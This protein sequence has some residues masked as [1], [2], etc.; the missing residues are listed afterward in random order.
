MLEFNIRTSV[1]SQED[2]SLAALSHSFPHIVTLVDTI[3]IVSLGANDAKTLQSCMRR[4]RPEV[5]RQI[6]RGFDNLA[7][8][9]D[10]KG[11]QLVFLAPLGV[12]SSL[13]EDRQVV[14]GILRRKIAQC[15]NASF[16]ATDSL[17]QGDRNYDEESTHLTPKGYSELAKVILPHIN[18][19]KKNT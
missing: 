1:K 15:P 12:T 19:H 9:G 2:A 11:V 6:N 7:S 8:A 18:R 16:V 14:E 13:S 5:L 17:H 3:I 4:E 10:V